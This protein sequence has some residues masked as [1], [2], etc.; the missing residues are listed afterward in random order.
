[1][2]TFFLSVLVLFASFCVFAQD[3]HY[4]I[5][6]ISISGNEKTKPQTILREFR[7]SVGDTIS[8]D[9]IDSEISTFSDNLHRL[10]LLDNINVSYTNIDSTNICINVKITERW[11]Y[12]V[13]P[14]LEIADRNLTSYFH[15]RD[16]SKI[17][18]GVA[19]DWLNFRGRNEMLNFKIRLGYKEHYAVSYQKPNIGKR[20]TGGI[21][22]NAEYFRQKKDIAYI[23]DNKPVYAENAEKYIR[24][25]YNIG[26]GY[27]YRPQTNYDFALSL[28]YQNITSKD[29]LLFTQIPERQEYFVPAF[30]FDYDNRDNKVCPKSG[31]HATL[32]AKT[33]VNTNAETFVFVNANFEYNDNIYRDKLFYNGKLS[34]KQFYGDKKLIPINKRIDLCNDYLIRGFDYYYITGKNFLNLQNTF[35]FKILNRRDFSLPKWIPAKFRTPYIQIL[36]DLF[37][38]FAYS[39]N[40]ADN[41]NDNNSLSNKPLYSVGT[42]FSFETYYDRVLKVYTAYNVNLNFIGVFVDYKT[43]IYKKF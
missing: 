11:Y 17:N 16:F 33:F 23:S 41:F 5:A 40:F 3:S 35:S 38:D 25:I 21:W 12:W 7:Y 29:S 32:D 39:S 27:I 22:L 8:A 2:K 20:K 13:Y 28:T 9:E 26:I 37:A 4:R 36:L 19:F 14:I 43:P 1:M 30:A 10:M 42:G 6:D 31:V 24:N 15:Y 18:Y 34:Y